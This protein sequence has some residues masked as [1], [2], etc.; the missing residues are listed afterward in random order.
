VRGFLIS[1]VLAGVAGIANA[2]ARAETLTF[3]SATYSSFRQL[4][5]DTPPDTL[6]EVR[7]T[8]GFP[9]AVSGRVSAVMVLHSLAGYREQN[10]GWHAAALREAGFATLT[11]DSFAAREMGDLVTGSPRQRP[12]YPSA[13]ADAFAALSALARDRASIPSASPSSVFRSVARSPM[14]RRLSDFAPGWVKAGNGLP[15]MSPTT[16]PGYTGWPPLQMPIPAPRS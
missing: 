12:P 8:L 5:T 11:Y 15:P 4:F 6:V 7:A 16:R 13:L 1:A 9:A 10:K 2:D 3:Q 14:T